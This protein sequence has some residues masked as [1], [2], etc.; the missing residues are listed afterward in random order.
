MGKL[1]TKEVTIHSVILVVTI[2]INRAEGCKMDYLIFN[3]TGYFFY[4][5]YNIIGY[6]GDQEQNGTGN[7]EIQDLLF[8]V[9]AIILTIVA[10][11]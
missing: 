6:W 11:V 4:S 10:L 3:F 9:H 8:A 7:V 1:Y 2:K 5:I